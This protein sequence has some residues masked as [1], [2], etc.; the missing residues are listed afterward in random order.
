[1]R[2]PTAGLSQ[3][4]GETECSLTVETH[5]RV[6]G[7]DE[8]A[9][10]RVLVVATVIAAATPLALPASRSMLGWISADI[11]VMTAPTVR[12]ELN[13]KYPRRPN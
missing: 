4:L 3:Q 9:D 5:R 6:S 12:Q 1:M 10:V 7:P 11:R 8:E 13:G 2:D